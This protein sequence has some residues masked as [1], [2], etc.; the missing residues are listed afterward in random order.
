MRVRG[1]ADVLLEG[2]E[3]EL[4]RKKHFPLAYKQC[5]PLHLECFC[6]MNL[7]DSKSVL[8]YL[9]DVHMPQV[10]KENRS[11]TSSERPMLPT[12][13]AHASWPLCLRASQQCYLELNHF[14]LAPCLTMFSIFIAILTLHF[15]LCQ[16]IVY[17]LRTF[18]A[19][20]FLGPLYSYITTIHFH[21]SLHCCVTIIALGS[22]W[23]H[24]ALAPLNPNHHHSFARIIAV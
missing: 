15:F 5:I 24:M 16:Q 9:N 22:L 14:I 4:Q 23:P 17:M 7:S 8:S 1:L 20:F 3:V 13:P 12:R 19:S 21:Q 11:T 6:P 10:I 2:R 18:A